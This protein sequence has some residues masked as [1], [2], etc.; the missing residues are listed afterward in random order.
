M[1][2]NPFRSTILSVAGLLM[3]LSS[4]AQDAPG[5]YADLHNGFSNKAFYA[6]P[7]G[8]Y[9]LWS[10]INH[11]CDSKRSDAFINLISPKGLRYSQSSLE[12]MVE[13]SV[14]L[15]CLSLSPMPKQL[16]NGKLLNNDNRRS[17]V[18]CVYGVE[19]SEVILRD[20]NRD[21]FGELRDQLK[22][23]MLNEGKK[24]EMYGTNYSY[25]IPNSK[26]DFDE[27]ML[28]NDKIVLTL[29]IEGAHALGHSIYIDEGLNEST[30]YRDMV[31]KNIDRLKGNAPLFDQSTEVFNKTIIYLSP[32]RAFENGFCGNA[33]YFLLEQADGISA[34]PSLNKGMSEIGKDA[35]KKLLAKE[36]G[37]RILIDMS[38]MSFES[39]RWFM[40]YLDNL[41]I[42]G[43]F[44]PA[45]AT[46]VGVCGISQNDPRFILP[47]D[48]KKNKGSFMSLWTQN[49]TNEEVQKIVATKGILGISLDEQVLGGDAYFEEVN[50]YM[51]GTKQRREVQLKLVLSHVFMAVKAGGKETW[52][53]LAIGSDFDNMLRPLDTYNSAEK[54]PELASDIESFLNDPNDLFNLVKSSDVKQLMYGY[55]A[56]DIVDMLMSKNAA[57][58]LRSQLP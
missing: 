8:K 39:R 56:K 4:F 34:D 55:S 37:K 16:F 52:K 48:S 45:V 42:L 54:F 1:N 19:A 31:F 33:P 23:L 50:K 17:S 12:S 25:V 9:N 11:T 32:S 38:H 47:D 24:H 58:F 6:Y 35:I 18:A 30:E 46:H 2:L 26:V 15:S 29:S 22:F 14:K 27:A 57:R 20:K 51:A 53:Y 7:M 5:A 40:K 49:L 44:V 10:R 43:D 21:Y 28:K 36:N 13:G 41:E 3:G